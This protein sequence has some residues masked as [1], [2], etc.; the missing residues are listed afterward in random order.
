MKDIDAKIE[1]GS[2]FE[3]A[4]QWYNEIFLR[5]AVMNAVMRFIAY[6]ILTVTV[7]A[8]YNIHNN[9]PLTRKV[10]V[11]ARLLDTAQ[12]YP[13]IKPL[14]DSHGIKKGVVRYLAER[15]ILAR[16]KYTPDFFA[17]NYYFIQQS[18]QTDVFKAYYDSLENKTNSALELYNRGYKVEINPISSE[19]DAKKKQISV[20]FEKKITSKKKKIGEILAYKATMISKGEKVN[21]K[22][23]AAWDEARSYN[24]K[25]KATMTFYMSNYDFNES[26]TKKLDFIVTSYKLEQIK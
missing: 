5:P 13:I 6:V 25:F 17:R 1:D 14:N 8:V 3:E 20:V 11:M 23:V 10:T 12:Y 16:E 9:F 26:V 7:I 4:K 24:P 2:Y 21:E 22:E 18:S 15:Y 19:Y